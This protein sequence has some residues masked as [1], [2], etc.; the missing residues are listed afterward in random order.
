MIMMPGPGRASGPGARPSDSD[1]AG[2]PG[3][4]QVGEIVSQLG[5]CPSCSVTLRLGYRAVT[6]CQ[7]DCHGHAVTMM[8]AR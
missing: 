2:G 1:R 7:F 3:G 4:V 5:K 8:M 6:G